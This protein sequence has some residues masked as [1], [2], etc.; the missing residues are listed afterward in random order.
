[1]GTLFCKK[2]VRTIELADVGLLF[3]GDCTRRAESMEVGTP[4]A[5]GSIFRI[6]NAASLKN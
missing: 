4:G 3:T 6:S 2:E 5:G 1:M